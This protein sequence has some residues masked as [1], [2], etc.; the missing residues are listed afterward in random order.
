MSDSAKEIKLVLSH[1]A[2]FDNSTNGK[3]GIPLEKLAEISELCGCPF[4]ERIAYAYMDRPMTGLKAE[5][6]LKMFSLLSSRASV[7]EKSRGE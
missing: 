1:Y 4:Y 2:Q 6:F 3:D 5:A 7:E